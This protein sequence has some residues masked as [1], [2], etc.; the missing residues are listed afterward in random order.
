M[1]SWDMD[2]KATSSLGSS[3]APLGTGTDLTFG[4][5]YKLGNWFGSYDYYA[6]DDAD[7]SSFGLG[8]SAP[9]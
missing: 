4:A 1:H 3:T 8:Y 5:G 6:I 7:L 9:F 2:G